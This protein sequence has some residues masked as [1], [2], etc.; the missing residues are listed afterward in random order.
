VVFVL[1]VSRYRRRPTRRVPILPAIR[2]ASF[3]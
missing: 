1:L 2:S 3:S